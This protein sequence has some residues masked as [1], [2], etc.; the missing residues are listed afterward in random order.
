M[1]KEF[2]EKNKIKEKGKEEIERMLAYGSIGLGLN[3]VEEVSATE[4]KLKEDIKNCR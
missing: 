3:P 2:N 1:E 4:A